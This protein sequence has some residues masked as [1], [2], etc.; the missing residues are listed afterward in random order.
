MQTKGSP[1]QHIE[2]RHIELEN[3]VGNLIIAEYQVDRLR[4]RLSE[5]IRRSSFESDPGTNGKAS[6]HVIKHNNRWYKISVK[7]EELD[8]MQHKKEQE[9]DNVN[10]NT[11]SSY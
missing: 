2:E 4:T 5:S 8:I 3:I 11:Y 1:K 6:T 10:G 9:E 7:I